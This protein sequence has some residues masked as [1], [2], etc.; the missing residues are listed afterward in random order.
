MYKFKN[1]VIEVGLK[2][3]SFAVIDNSLTLSQ[4]RP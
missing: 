2:I 3:W 1:K 4:H